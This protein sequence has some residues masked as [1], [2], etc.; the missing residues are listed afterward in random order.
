MFECVYVEVLKCEVGV[1]FLG[2]FWYA[3]GAI[4]VESFN[5]ALALML[6]V[7]WMVL[8]IMILGNYD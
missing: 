3:R 5:E 8:M 6:S 2:D 1:V 7:K 4:L